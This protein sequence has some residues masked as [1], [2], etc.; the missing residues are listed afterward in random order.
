MINVELVMNLEPFYEDS[1][2]QT[3]EYSRI[4]DTR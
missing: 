4:G 1:T 2:I 3:S